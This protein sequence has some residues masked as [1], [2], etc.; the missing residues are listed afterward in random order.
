MCAC[1]KTQNNINNENDVEKE[2]SRFNE[3]GVTEDGFSFG[4]NDKNEIILID[5]KGDKKQII[6]PESIK[7]NN[8][9]YDIKEIF[10][11]TFQSNNEVESIELPSSIISIGQY[12]FA[13]CLN[14]ENLKISKNLQNIEG[15]AF[16][17]CKK[18]EKVLFSKNF[19][20]IDNNAFYNCNGIS[21]YFQSDKKQNLEFSLNKKII[22]DCKDCGK[23]KEGIDYGIKNDGKAIITSFPNKI[24]VVFPSEIIHNKNVT[25]VSYIHKDTLK[26]FSNEESLT[27]SIIFSDNITIIQKG[28]FNNCKNLVDVKL[29]RNLTTIYSYFFDEI[30][31][32]IQNLWIPKSIKNIHK[33]A[34]AFCYNLNLYFEADNLPSNCKKINYSI[35]LYFLNCKRFCKTENGISYIIDSNDELL[36]TNI[37]DKI[38]Y[39]ELP[40]QIIENNKIYKIE[41]LNKIFHNKN[42]I[43]KVKLPKSLKI[44]ES[45]SFVKCENLKEVIFNSGLE[46]ICQN[47]FNNCS[48]FNKIFIPKNVK[49]IESFAFGYGKKIFAECSKKNDYNSYNKIFW[50]CKNSDTFIDDYKF[51]F[52]LDKNNKARLVNYTGE[53]K[54]IKI[55]EILNYKNTNY[56]IYCIYEFD[57]LYLK[58]IVLNN[59]Q[60]ICKKAFFNCS[61]LERIFIPKDIRSI[62]ENFVENNTIILVSD[63][64]QNNNTKYW[65]NFTDNNYSVVWDCVAYGKF[66]AFNYA[67]NSKKEVFLTGYDG[68]RK[69]V[70]IPS[71][72]K[73]KKENLKV[74]NICNNAFSKYCIAKFFYIPNTIKNIG[75]NAFEYSDKICVEDKKEDVEWY[76]DWTAD[77]TVLWNVDFII[78]DNNYTYAITK[79]KKATI[80]DYH[81]SERIIKIPSIVKIRNINYKVESI[82]K[83]CF[84]LELDSIYIPKSIMYIKNGAFQISLYHKKIYIEVASKPE[85][86][87]EYWFTKWAD[88]FENYDGKEVIWDYK[89]K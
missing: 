62:G 43:E 45:N 19:N 36:L 77:F 70:R 12:A 10:E 64:K 4:R 51:E 79:N 32:K 46:T 21:L 31:S 74:E 26:N 14:L 35:N 69:L 55:P 41:K 59:T 56:Q 50:N 7:Y 81:N 54:E 40:S 75:H 1:N 3:L 23:T 61:N 78:N 84:D 27:Q 38:K 73:Y 39:L 22:L 83:S 71:I 44:I 33:S 17:N 15:Y 11:H 53:L 48:K 20:S 5:Y 87:E 68:G 76:N 80:L 86:W 58:Q 66:N 29:P 9:S 60:I 25:M 85:G 37:D 89:N 67:I 47:A 42:N 88:E 82:E 28:F 63:K 13:N 18:I 30:S 57:N 2:Y 72:I 49:K 6:I 34:F 16:A 52:Y 65:D 24:N 8:V